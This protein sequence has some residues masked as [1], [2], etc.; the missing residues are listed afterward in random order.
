MKLTTD[1][2]QFVEVHIQ[3]LE[4]QARRWRAQ[5]WFAVIFFLY[6]IGFLLVIDHVVPRLP[7]V[8]DEI[9]SPAAGKLNCTI[10]E[11][12]TYVDLKA[13]FIYTE[14]ILYT[15]AIL[16]A[17]VVTGVFVWTFSNSKKDKQDLLLAK[18]LRDL[19]EQH[20]QEDTQQDA[21]AVPLE[22]A[23]NASFIVR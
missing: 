16:V 20:K 4:K 19:L 12:R 2:V 7:S 14:M 10:N 17:L 13:T 21:S 8:T 9:C 3:K 23:Q 22:A 1:E 15:D 18:F 6:G 5:K 11:M